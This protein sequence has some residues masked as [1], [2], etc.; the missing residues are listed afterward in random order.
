MTKAKIFIPLTIDELIVNPENDRHGQLPEGKTPIDW[1][2][3][4][5]GKEIRNLAND[6][7]N[8]Q[9]VYE[10]PLVE[11]K[12]KGYLVWDGN[13]RATALKLLN[14][15]SLAKNESHKKYFTDLSKKM[16][17]LPKITCEVQ[18]NAIIRDEILERRHSG[19]NNGVGQIKWDTKAGH[20]F[21]VRKGI[22]KF[23]I[24]HEVRKLLLSKG[25]IKETDKVRT[26]N[27]DKILLTKEFRDMVGVSVDEDKLK[28]TKQEDEVL[29]ALNKIAQDT[30]S[31]D[32]TLTK[33]LRSDD[34]R[35]YLKKLNE[36]GYISGTKKLK[37][38]EKP[39]KKKIAKAKKNKIKKPIRVHLI[40][41]NNYD[42]GDDPKLNR[43]R[44]IWHEL[45]FDLNLENHINAISVLTRVMIDVAVTFYVQK[46]NG[47]NLNKN[48]EL[49][50]KIKK[51]TAHMHG[52]GKIDQKRQK[53]IDALCN[54]KE[55]LSMRS[56]NG[57]VH[58]LKDF[59]DAKDLA[60]LWDNLQD[61][62]LKCVE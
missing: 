56:L 28:F 19:A 14:N 58:S 7:V 42:L 21:N 33:L 26:S 44:D 30:I 61:F 36:S 29:R 1:M 49:Q 40:R 20:N 38:P 8:Q 10:T 48:A 5:K 27:I 57:F 46:N 43:F 31:G 45:Q 9:A 41:N 6:I 55:L 51:V 59:P 62:I 17:S 54:N 50:E 34:K 16:K 23:Q 32:L 11:K 15:P 2:L 4:N 12:D 24:G 18:N 37:K 60:T 39:S 3:E 47:L 25:L 13:R 22:K 35:D 53:Q 52:K